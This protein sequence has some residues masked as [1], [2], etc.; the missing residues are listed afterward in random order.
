MGIRPI[1][2]TTEYK[3]CPYIWSPWQGKPAGAV[4]KKMFRPYQDFTDYILFRD[5]EPFRAWRFDHE[6]RFKQVTVKL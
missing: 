3:P 1:I 6:P 5:G 2:K 4:V